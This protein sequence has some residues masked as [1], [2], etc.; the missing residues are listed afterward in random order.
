MEDIDAVAAPV[1]AAQVFDM[2][3]AVSRGDLDQAAEI[4]TAAMELLESRRPA[5]IFPW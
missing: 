2:T 3:G 5:S 1:L 4:L